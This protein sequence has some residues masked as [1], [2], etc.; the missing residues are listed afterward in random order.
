MDDCTYRYL[1]CGVKFDCLNPRVRASG[2]LI[3][4]RFQPKLLLLLS[5]VDYKFDQRSAIQQI[6]R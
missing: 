1:Y 3:I 5:A 2:N 4:L 6:H